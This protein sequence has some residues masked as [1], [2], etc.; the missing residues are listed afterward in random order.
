MF[1]HSPRSGRKAIILHNNNPKQWGELCKKVK[2]LVEARDPKDQYIFI[3][4]WNE[5]GEGNYMEPDRK[6]GRAY[7]NEA[8]KAFLSSNQAH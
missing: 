1:D 3:K 5:W 4:S 7:I 6:F 8:G 2:E